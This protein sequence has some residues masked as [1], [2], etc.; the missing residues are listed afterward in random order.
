MRPLIT[1]DVSTFSL[2]KQWII[3]LSLLCIALS[4]NMG[5]WPTTPGIRR[6]VAWHLLKDSS[7][8]PSSMCPRGT[9]VLLAAIFDGLLATVALV[10]LAMAPLGRLSLL[11]LRLTSSQKL[12][13]DPGAQDLSCFT[14][15]MTL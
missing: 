2:L 6:Q 5:P 3:S 14:P 13:I 7:C 11:G 12:L 9:V 8:R 15:L 4:M 1:F 10:L